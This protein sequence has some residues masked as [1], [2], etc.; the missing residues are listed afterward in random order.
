MSDNRPSEEAAGDAPADGNFLARFPCFVPVSPPFAFDRATRQIVI[1]G[2]NNYFVVQSGNAISVLA[3]TDRHLAKDFLAAQ[4]LIGDAML[5]RVDTP[6]DLI[7][8]VDGIVSRFGVA[9]EHLPKVL[10]DKSKTHRGWSVPY[11][12]LRDT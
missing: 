10:F 4:D 1:D 7:A 9:P 12:A 5:L 2:S 6:D 11:R 3:F 8:L